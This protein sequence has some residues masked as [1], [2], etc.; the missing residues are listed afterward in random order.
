[1]PLKPQT[2]PMNRLQ[3]STGELAHGCPASSGLAHAPFLQ[4][5]GAL[6]IVLHG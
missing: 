2:S 1:M 6:Q 4:I 5:S 3:V